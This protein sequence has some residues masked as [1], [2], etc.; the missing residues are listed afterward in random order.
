VNPAAVAAVALVD[1]DRAELQ[2]A[3]GKHPLA[4]RHG[5]GGHPL[6]S[7]AAFVELA[8]RHPDGLVEHHRGDR[9]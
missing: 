5:L 7:R 3:M 2:A 4:L 1:L 6:P 9:A 8:S